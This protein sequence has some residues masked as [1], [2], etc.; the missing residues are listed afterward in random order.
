MKTC[1]TCR[2]M[3]GVEWPDGAYMCSRIKENMGVGDREASQGDLAMIDASHGEYSDKL[4]V[5]GA[6]GCV[7]HEDKGA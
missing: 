5:T 7:L 1:A 6:F 2:F 3:V 4:I